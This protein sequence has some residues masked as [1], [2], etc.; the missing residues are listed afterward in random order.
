MSTVNSEFAEKESALRQQAEGSERVLDGL[1]AD[2]HAIDANLESLAERHHQYDL[3]AKICTSLDE[4]DDLGAA[5]LF[6]SEDAPGR[7]REQLAYARRNIEEF[8]EQ[9]A[10]VEG[11]RE[12]VVEQIRQQNSELDF[13]HY[14]LQALI[15][16]EEGRKNEW[17][18]EREADEPAETAQVMPWSRGY[19]EDRRSRR[20]VSTSLAASLAIAFILSM[21]AIPYSDRSEEAQLPERVAS[22]VRQE[23]LPPPPPPVQEPDF[24]DEEIPEPEVEEEAAQDPVPEAAEQPALADAA[25]PDTREQVRSRGILAFSESFANRA[26]MTTTAQIGSDARVSDAGV[27]SVGRPERMMVS[28]SAPGTSGGINLADISRNVGGGGEGLDGVAVTRVASNI[29]AGDGPARPLAGGVPAGRTDEEIQIVFDR[30]KAAL[31]R[32]YNREL[33]RDPTLRGQLV[34]Q[35]TIEPDGTVSMCQL[36]SSDMDSPALADQVVQRVSTFDF[37]AKEDIV[38]ITII[39]PIDFLPAA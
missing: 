7:G 35:L 34:L 15:E 5:H 29:G 11:D 38:A 13:L 2:L 20:S 10:R 1:Q 4:L 16:E 26:D 18:V 14:D 36:F 28:T 21:I 6:W 30:Y 33:R 8:G 37:G 3:L 12:A 27:D 22:L 31:Y 23:R 24:P 19:E 17:I 25:E 32:M 9:V 39:Y